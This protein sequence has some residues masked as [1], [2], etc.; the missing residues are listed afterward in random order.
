MAEL[1]EQS[2]TLKKQS[3]YLL[4]VAKRAVEIAIGKNEKVALEFM[5]K[6][7]K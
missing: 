6:E 3:E 7:T 4:E 5:N 2:F 1:I